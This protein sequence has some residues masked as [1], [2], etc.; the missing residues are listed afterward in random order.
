VLTVDR[1]VEADGISITDVV[2]RQP[3][4]RG[5]SEET[6][7][8]ALVFVRRGCFVRQA[9]GTSHLLDP[10][11]AYCINPGEEQ[12][13]DHP[14]AHGDVCTS[15]R[16]AP[17]LL[18]SLWGGDPTLPATPLPSSPSLDVEHRMLV[19][20]ARRSVAPAELYEHTLALVAA[21]LG[22]IDPTRVAAGRSASVRARQSLVDAVREALAAEIDRSLPGLAKD[23]HVSPHHLS[24][25]FRAVTGHTIARHRMRLRARAALERL[26]GGEDSLAQVAADTGFADQ[27]HLTKV[28]RRETG[29]TPSALRR[30]L[31][32]PDQLHHLV[33]SVHEHGHQWAA[34]HPG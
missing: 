7:H 16:L 17:G 25:T 18:A 24:R 10:T 6:G 26:A 1:L 20:A 5:P 12:R 19:A 31:A 2:C 14:H 3:A 9:G 33:A 11:R 13:Y 4:G 27:S 32:R 28:I 21:A 8:H 15:V 30:A 23:L 29:Y 34:H 22:Q